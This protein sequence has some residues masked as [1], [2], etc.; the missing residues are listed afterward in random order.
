[1]AGVGDEI[2]EDNDG[3]WTP[4][5]IMIRCLL[6]KQAGLPSPCRTGLNTLHET[7]NL[8]PSTKQCLVYPLSA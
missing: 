4:E 5:R 2:V 1:M 3:E 7:E 8:L 6:I